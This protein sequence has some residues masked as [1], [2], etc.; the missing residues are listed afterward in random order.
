MG[1]TACKSP[2]KIVLFSFNLFPWIIWI[3]GTWLPGFNEVFSFLC[4]LKSNLIWNGLHLSVRKPFGIPFKSLVCLKMGLCLYPD[5]NN[6]DLHQSQHVDF[7]NIVLPNGLSKRRRFLHTTWTHFQRVYPG[8]SAIEGVCDCCIS[9][10]DVV[11][12]HAFGVHVF[13]IK[14]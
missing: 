14:T 8:L 10:M 4:N 3:L 7:P 12:K 5:C 6:P 13:G 9:G 1:Q 11:G 2:L